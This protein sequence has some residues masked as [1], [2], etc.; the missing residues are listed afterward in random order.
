MSSANL[1]ATISAA[2]LP[3][4]DGG[5]VHEKWLNCARDYPWYPLPFL[6]LAKNKETAMVQKANLWF[7]DPNRLH[8]LL[9]ATDPQEDSWLK[10]QIEL[11]LTNNTQ[12]VEE[13][14]VISF[15][16]G[17]TSGDIAVESNIINASETELPVVQDAFTEEKSTNFQTTEN[18][19]LEPV[20]TVNVDPFLNGELNA[21][22]LERLNGRIES[23]VNG[24]M[25]ANPEDALPA[26]A[27]KEP[28]LFEPYHSVD[29]F[30][31]MGIKVDLNEVPK[32]TF[33]RQLKSFTQ[34]LKTMKKV[35]I[36]E[37]AAADPLVEAQ[38]NQSNVNK[39]I[40]TEAMAQV[41]V[42]Q[43]KHEK[44][45]EIYQKLLLLHPEKSVFFA[46]QIE[47]LKNIQ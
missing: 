41:L 29:Y 12:Y 14:Q 15:D 17:E 44:A 1:Q 2:V 23:A 13:E 5:S 24:I 30:A 20:T 40:V 47:Q 9:N 8:W 35:T 11:Q 10:E 38:A 39:E 27:E 18:I 25:P 16:Q 3:Y 46:A 45:A 21:G 33:D 4:L 7:S 43:G 22:H 19:E 28:M 26:P 42:K 32:D 31:S 6:M 36:P 37:A 34:W